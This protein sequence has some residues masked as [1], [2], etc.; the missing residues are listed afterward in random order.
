MR[1]LIFTPTWQQDY[2]T[3]MHPDCAESV[4][5]QKI[6]G[7]MDWLVRWTNAHPIGDHRNVL[8]HYRHAQAVFLA[9]HYDALLTVEHDNVLP[10]EHAVQRLLETPG[11]VVYAPYMLRHGNY[12][13]SLWQYRSDGRL[14]ASLMHHPA[15]L[16]AAQAANI[17]RVCGA[18]FGCTLFR[19]HVLEAIPFA[20]SPRQFCPDLP[21][22]QQALDAEFLSLARLDVPV[23]HVDHDGY[24]WQPFQ[25]IPRLPY[26]A[27]TTVA[28]TVAD[29]TRV[30]LVAGKW[31]DLT[32]PQAKDLFTLGLVY[33]PD[34]RYAT[35]AA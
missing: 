31:I 24:V 16:A 22:A 27:T 20:P 14:G 19:R 13:L 18:G 15:E 3:A 9:G 26:L 1:L 21:F 35:E 23:A 25:E 7:D 33:V 28:A 30:Q 2:G 29:G 12:Q 4:Q 17:W 32:K 6:A 10:D 11:D 8:D 34:T 5:G